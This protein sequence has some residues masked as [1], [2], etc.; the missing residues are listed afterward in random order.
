VPGRVKGRGLSIRHD[1]GGQSDTHQYKSKSLTRALLAM[2]RKGIMNTW[3][4]QNLQK[5]VPDENEHCEVA[6]VRC[7]TRRPSLASHTRIS[8]T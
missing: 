6:R 1:R 4:F 2:T 3:P 8:K 5:Y 7:E